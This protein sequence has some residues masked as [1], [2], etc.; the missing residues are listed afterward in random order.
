MAATEAFPELGNMLGLTPSLSFGTHFVL[1]L[2]QEGS[3]KVIRN[4]SGQA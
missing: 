2:S 4:I 1:K 3:D